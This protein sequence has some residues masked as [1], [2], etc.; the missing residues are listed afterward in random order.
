[1]LSIRDRRPEPLSSTHGP[2]VVP[3]AL[4]LCLGSVLAA[5]GAGDAGGVP[6]WVPDHPDAET[7]LV[8]RTTEGDVE[9]GVAS[10]QAP[11]PVEEVAEHYRSAIESAGMAFSVETFD[12]PEGAGATVTGSSPDG[13]R[14]LHLT[15]T[16]E[17]EA[18][19]RVV[20]NFSETG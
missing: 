1:M 6:D 16:P 7:V 17:S 9:R 12:L 13:A 20:I 15:V 4:V 5:C 10:V 2:R 11:G 14:G 18:R 3:A 19:S 8:D